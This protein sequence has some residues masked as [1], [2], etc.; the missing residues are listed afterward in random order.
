[1]AANKNNSTGRG[2]SLDELQQLRA[3]NEVKQVFL[4]EQLKNSYQAALATAS[5][6]TTGG[7]LARI[8]TF[9]E[10]GM[11]VASLGIQTYRNIR[12]LVNLFKSLK[13]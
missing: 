13:N 12:Q 2:Y 3:I 9:M 4:T 7:P 10:N 8:N 5:E 6:A 1:M 11:A